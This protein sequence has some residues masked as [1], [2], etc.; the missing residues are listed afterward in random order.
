MKLRPAFSLFAAFALPLCPSFGQEEP[1]AKGD[2]DSPYEQIKVLAKAMQLIRKDY[3]D[4]KKV[5]YEALTRAALR[6]MLQSLDP[7]SQYMEPENFTDMKEMTDSHFGGLGIHVT[8]RN[9]DLVIVSPMEDSPGFKAGLMPGDQLIKIDGKSTEKMDLN[10]AS[11]KLR[12]TVG[13]HVTLTILRPGTKEIKEFD[14]TREVIKVWSVKDA[15][16]LPAD[17]SAP[18]AKIG[19]V[20]ITQFNAPT[21]EELAKK[22]DELEKKGM[23]ALVIDLRYNPGGLIQ[24]AVDTAGM[25]LPP[26][27][28]V[29]TTE[30][31]ASSQKNKYKMSNSGLRRKQNYPLAV[32]INFGSASGSELAA[33][34]L[35]DTNRAIIVGET[36]FGKGSVQSV[37]PM[38][39]GSA[40]RLTTAK[41]YTPGHQVIHE[42][43]IIPTIRATMT[44]EQERQLMLSRREDLTEEQ[45]KKDLANFHDT[46]LDR[47]VDAL[48]GVLVFQSRKPQ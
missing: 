4:E 22:V 25:F 14:L 48:K 26:E 10:D 40:I 38:P 21:S 8:E 12:G 41:Y 39:D 47:A 29:C 34:A 24:T 3:V 20:R 43:G 46:Q 18:D 2:P 6:G 28:V 45:R 5:N 11:E 35:K 37:V 13:T 42:H 44:P 31:R 36:S 15:K 23:Q 27:T 19:Y 16:I 17:A 9:G 7:H 33:G 1:A 32:L 30:G